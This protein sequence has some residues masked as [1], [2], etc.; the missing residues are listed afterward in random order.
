MKKSFH[1]L[2]RRTTLAPI[3][4]VAVITGIWSIIEL[5]PFLAY[6]HPINAEILVVEGWVPESYMPPVVQEFR[7][8]KYR[9]IVTVGGPMRSWKR[10]GTPASDA[11]RSARI[12]IQLGIEPS[13]ITAVSSSPVAVHKTWSFAEAFRDWTVES[14]Y[15]I[16]R[17]NVFTIGVHARKSAL[18]FQRALGPT[19]QVGIISAK[20]QNYDP[21]RW[22]LSPRGIY[23]VS[24]NAVAYLDALLLTGWGR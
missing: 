24:K 20:E 18:L 5:H 22:W 10:T 17:V 16:Q 19:I 23:I 9:H 6:H 3:I 8:G 1:F 12:L 2:P 4:L 7:E 15:V 21:A 13:T 11:E 14:G